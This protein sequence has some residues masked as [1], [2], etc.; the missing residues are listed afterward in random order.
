MINECKHIKNSDQLITTR[1]E[2][3]SGFVAMALEKNR[4]AVPYV[5]E[6]RALKAEASKVVKPMDLLN[7][8]SIR[9]ALLTASGLSDKALGHLEE[10]D[11]NEAIRGLI[12]YFLEPCGDGFVD[13]LVYRFLL[14]RGDSLGGTMRNLAG[15]LAEQKFKRSVVAALNLRK[16]KFIW[17]SKKSNK[18]ISGDKIDSDVD[19]INGIHWQSTNRTLVFNKNVKFINKNID[20][21]LINGTHESWKKS[22]LDA[23]AFIA[24]GELKGGIDPAGA[25]EHWKTARSALDRIVDGFKKKKVDVHTFFIGAAIESAMAQEIWDWL[26]TGRLSYAGNLTNEDHV[27]S[28]CG[29]LVDL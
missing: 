13:E 2:V 8:K 17:L 26:N 23:N 1:A 28:L 21:C 10:N 5:D 24:L 22:M 14:I 15:Y 3:R 11:K 9:P 19:D 20:I 16:T 18:W 25:D 12:E 29:W 27:A 6:A 7:I 4:R